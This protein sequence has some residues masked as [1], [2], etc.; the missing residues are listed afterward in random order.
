MCFNIFIQTSPGFAGLALGAMRLVFRLGSNYITFLEKLSDMFGKMASTLPVYEKYVKILRTRATEPKQ[1]SERLLK[2]LA[3]VYSDIIQFCQYACNLFKKRKGIRFKAGFVNSLIWAPFDQRFS[4]LVIRFR[5]C[6]DLFKLEMD[7][8]STDEAIRFYQ[9]FDE[10]IHIWECEKQHQDTKD[11]AEEGMI[12]AFAQK[13]RALNTGQWFMNITAYKEWRAGITIP[14]QSLGKRVLLIQGKPGYGKTTLCGTIIEDL[15]N[16]A[17]ENK[18]DSEVPMDV[19]FYFF[20]KQRKTSNYA[21]EAFRAVLAQ[22][23]HHYRRDKQ[24]I[25]IASFIWVDSITKQSTA[26]IRDISSALC[27]ILRQKRRVALVFDG[28]DECDDKEAF[29]EDLYH[30]TDG[31]Y[32][33]HILLSGRPTIALPQAFRTN[34]SLIG[35]TASQNLRDIERYL[36]PKFQELLDS[37]VLVEA[38]DSDPGGIVKRV[39]SR[40][41]R[42]FLWASLLVTYLQSPALTIRQRRDAI[43]NLNRLEGL[44]AL[45]KAIIQ[46]LQI[47]FPAQARLNIRRAFQWVARARRP[48]HIN[49]LQTV[50]AI[51]VSGPLEEDSVIP[52]FEKSLCLMSG[53]L[54]EVATDQTVQFIHL[55]VAEY[56]SGPAEAGRFSEGLG[57]QFV[58]AFSDRYLAICCLSYLCYTITA[59][60]LSGFSSITPDASDTERRY[61]ALRYVAQ[62]WSHHLSGSLNCS[63]TS[64][65]PCPEDGSWQQ[66]IQLA[67][68]FLL[69]R[70]RVT[71]WI[72]ASWLFGNPP[73]IRLPVEEQRAL[74]RLGMLSPAEG[75]LVSKA[76]SHLERWS[77]DLE[78]LNDSWAHVLKVNPNEIWEPS[79]STFTRSD[80]WLTVPGAKLT[81]IAASDNTGSLRSLLICSQVSANGR[82]VGLVRLSTSSTLPP[83]TECWKASYEIWSLRTNEII[84]RFNLDLLQ[85]DLSEHEFEFPTAISSDLRTVVI[86]GSAIKINIA[87]DSTVV[88]HCWLDFRRIVGKSRHTCAFKPTYRVTLSPSGKYLLV[89]RESVVLVERDATTLSQVWFLDIYCWTNLCTGNQEQIVHFASQEFFPPQGAVLEESDRDFA[90]HQHLPQLVFPRSHGTVMWDFS[91]MGQEHTYPIHDAPLEE[92]SFSDN[93]PWIFGWTWRTK[94]FYE[95]EQERKARRDL[96]KIDIAKN[97]WALLEDR[98]QYRPSL[99]R[100]VLKTGEATDLQISLLPTVQRTGNPTLRQDA[101]GMSSVSLLRQL[102]SD[103]AIV[104]QSLREDGMLKSE[105]LTRLP[106]SIKP[107]VALLNPSQGEGSETVRLVLN[108][109]LQNRYS[110]ANLPND[111]LPAILERPQASIPTVVGKTRMSLGDGRGRSDEDYQLKGLKR[112]MLHSDGQDER[113]KRKRW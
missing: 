65:A 93:G 45:Y 112:L 107:N 5:D 46:S 72:E 28:I 18:D 34:C 14:G 81:P 47:H 21:G 79:I 71:V 113:T 49:E 64:H 2:A 78:I 42:M 63:S 68:A 12:C 95:S 38:H 26:T 15:Q 1:L 66:V 39:S 86:L 3:Y 111:E 56:L 6:T 31:A 37:G 76:F 101:E 19:L 91:K 30:I 33:C 102:E 44:D 48:L 57:L 90:F 55:S 70:R 22:L 59:E 51:P 100:C 50:I 43:E 84:Y 109:P 85:A 54:L 52:N 27:L 62:Y 83:G 29:F 69:D 24:L 25:D 53:A 20:A 4:H 103:G 10:T 94:F 67:A 98:H 106:K 99:S 74:S 58:P 7:L 89:I 32:H 80:F 40:A 61:P 108:K 82:E 96:I 104:L 105:T 9:K 13:Q 16:A 87:T 73:N 60:P 110:L 11:E 77:S 35:L 97:Y 88:S 17:L 36:S 75:E 23:L 41:N 92:L 8:V